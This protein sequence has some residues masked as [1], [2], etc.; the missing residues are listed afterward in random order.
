MFPKLKLALFVSGGGTTM[1][2][3][4]IACLPG[5]ILN[6]LIEVVLVIASKP[7]IGAI[8]KAKK[9]GLWENHIVVCEST[10]YQT[11]Y[12]YGLALLEIL[13]HFEVNIILQAGWTPLTPENVVTEYAGRIYNEHPE[14]LD[15]GHPD[16]GGQGMVGLAAHQARI[17]FLQET[18]PPPEER[19]TEV[20]CHRVTKKYDEGEVIVTGR[21]PVKLDDTA[22]SLQERAL[23]LEWLVQIFALYMIATNSVRTIQRTERVVKPG[24]EGILDAC[25]RKAM[26]MYPF[27]G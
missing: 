15:H 21:V 3:I 14:F 20:C 6:G 11:P 10:S 19:F 25:K 18:N 23:P 8:D 22:E 12:N 9:L 17:L 24:Q 1:E 26:E 13:H 27:H 7:G 4:L 2:Q 5:G 16:F